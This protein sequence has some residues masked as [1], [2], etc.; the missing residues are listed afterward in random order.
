[1]LGSI[2]S[3]QAVFILSPAGFQFCA[4]ERTAT[5]EKAAAS[6]N[7]FMFNDDVDSPNLCNYAVKRHCRFVFSKQLRPFPNKIKHFNRK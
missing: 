6:N 3:A 7:D 5:K 1:L 4:M 2:F